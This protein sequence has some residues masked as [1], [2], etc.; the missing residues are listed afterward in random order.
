M[1]TLTANHLNHV[2]LPRVMMLLLT[3]TLM[4]HLPN[5]NVTFDL[6]SM[7][8]CRKCHRMCQKVWCSYCVENLCG[9]Y[10]HYR[11]CSKLFH[12]RERVLSDIR[13]RSCICKINIEL[14]GL[15]CAE[16]EVRELDPQDADKYGKMVNQG[17][18]RYQAQI[19][20]MQLAG[21]LLSILPTDDSKT[22]SHHAPGKGH[23][24]C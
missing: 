12:D 22:S 1:L 8:T 11:I 9:D 15:V 23:N 21:P 14:R 20:V 3:S 16:D 10:I 13:R 18:R 4:L 7:L 6:V 2:C 19:P 17:M 5:S 24:Y